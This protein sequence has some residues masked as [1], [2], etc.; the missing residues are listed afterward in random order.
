MNQ[1]SLRV[2][3]FALLATL[4]SFALASLTAQTAD[5]A[6]PPSQSYPSYPSAVTTAKS[7]K[8]SAATTAS[9]SSK[10]TRVAKASKA[11]TASSASGTTAS[12]QSSSAT[13][14]QDQSS[15]GLG[16]QF[17][18]NLYTVDKSLLT[19]TQVGDEY[20]YRLR[21]TALADIAHVH[22][23]EHLPEGL[24][25]VRA[26]PEANASGK[27]LTWMWPAMA[28]GEVRDLLVTVRPTAEGNYVTSTMV[29]VDPVVVLPLFAGLP[30]LEIN[31]TGPAVAEIGE[32][33]PYTI[34]IRN[35]GT[36]IARNVQ[37]ADVLPEGLT[38]ADSLNVSLGDLAPNESKTINVVAQSAAKGTFTNT[39][40]A[41]YAGGDQPVESQA[42]VSIV[43]SRLSI[44]KTGPANQFVF[45]TATY[46]INVRNDGDTTLNNV[47]VTDA[48]PAGTEVVSAPG[49]EVGRGKVT[50]NIASLAPGQVATQEITLTASE[51][52]T[53]TNHATVAAVS[54]TGRRINEQAQAV[55]EWEGAP[56]VLTELTDTN[57]PI[58]VGGS[59][60]YEIRITNQGTFKPVN[61][62][63]KLV[64]SDN[65]RPVGAE[66][67]ARGTIS[68][69][70]I[71]FDD[72]L[73]KP[74]GVIKLR[75]PVQA[76]KSGV[77]K[78]RMEFMSSFLPEPFVKEESTFVY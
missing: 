11:A 61:A 41:S 32:K 22:V 37:V 34:T 76:V 7:S 26:D 38:T 67:D 14:G 5:R 30:R 27:D 28:K 15:N 16:S 51:P 18:S 60:T 1:P 68:G 25:F 65:V 44:T 53:T 54:A 46:Q 39:A 52:S 6:N 71:V 47:V 19:S 43:D 45:A 72:V 40:R 24:D 4:T 29:C 12:A 57:D 66:G 49:G 78:A 75:V 48:V 64:L 17:N 58:R 21:I 62:R 59:T 8:A 70:E 42:V 50:W 3:A 13:S 23:V 36:A 33:I 69:Q 63:V 56:G 73:L 2:K 35:S 20:Q 10:S 55:T 9:T 31:K 74:R 77:A